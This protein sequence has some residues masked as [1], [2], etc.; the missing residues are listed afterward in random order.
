MHRCQAFFL[1][2]GSYFFVVPMKADPAMQPGCRPAEVRWRDPLG[3]LPFPPLALSRRAPQLSEAEI[4]VTWRRTARAVG[5]LR[6]LT[7]GQLQAVG[8]RPPHAQIRSGWEK[9]TPLQKEIV[10]DLW[11]KMVAR[12]QWGSINDGR[13]LLGQ[14]RAGLPGYS[15]GMAEAGPGRLKKGAMWRLVARDV[16]LPGMDNRLVNPAE[17]S[18]T[19]RAFLEE[20]GRH[21][22]LDPAAIN[23][24]AYRA[25]KPYQDPG[26]DNKANRYELALRMYQAKML[27]YVDHVEEKV[28]V[29]TVIKK[30]EES[31]AETRVWTR[32]VGDCR[33]ANLK[34]KKAPWVPLGSPAGLGLLELSP[35][36]LRERTIGTYQGDVP[37]MFY[38]I[39]IPKELAAWFVLPDLEPLELV[40][41]ARS[42]GVELPAPP[43][44]GSP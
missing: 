28:G 42:R 25:I 33:R 41:F 19:V 30:V 13:A 18:R 40:K 7:R 17:H 36:M 6:S 10:T 23:W 35:D 16:A 24:E 38:R 9:A 15:D 20:P 32:L 31:K 39:G 29:F 3:D 37:D 26:W 44:P 1:G 34:F 11:D 27:R 8:A 4:Q 43:Q 2:G 22:L 12:A 5:A 21:M 14:L